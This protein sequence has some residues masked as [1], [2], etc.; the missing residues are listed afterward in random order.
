VK[1]AAM[2]AECIKV[3]ET[4]QELIDDRRL[5]GATQELS[6][7]MHCAVTEGCEHAAACRDRIDG[8]LQNVQHAMREEMER[9]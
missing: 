4:S 1:E 7:L 2:L 5:E 9:A 3:A 8:L 6:Q